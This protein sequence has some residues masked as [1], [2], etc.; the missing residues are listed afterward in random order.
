MDA[1]QARRQRRRIV[2]DQQVAGPQQRRQLRARGML[3]PPLRIDDQQLRVARPL[4]RC[5][6]A[7]MR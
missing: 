3:Q 1:V 7:L 4:M 5:G 2:G 6:G